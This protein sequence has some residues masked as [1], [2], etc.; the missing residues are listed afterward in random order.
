MKSPHLSDEELVRLYLSTRNSAYFG[1]LYQR[2]IKKVYRRCLSITQ[3]PIDAE[4][5]SHDI[6]VRV[7]S[8]L[9]NY[10]QKATFSTW[11]YTISSNYCIDRIKY[12]QKRTW[13]DLDPQLVKTLVDTDEQSDWEERCQLID[14]A[15]HRMDKKEVGYLKMRYYDNMNIN[16]IALAMNVKSSAVKMRLKRIRDKVRGL[17]VRYEY[18]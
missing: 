13:V 17:V 7:L 12:G 14:K 10:Q 6:F 9:D 11:L 16:E 5:F 8:A 18:S 2:Y 1:Q 3:N 4:D 15:I